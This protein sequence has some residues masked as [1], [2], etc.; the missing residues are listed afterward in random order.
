MATNVPRLSDVFAQRTRGAKMCRRPSAYSRA[1]LSR[2]Y[3]MGV[4]TFSKIFCQ[5]HFS[6]NQQSMNCTFDTDAEYY[7]Y[8]RYI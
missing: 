7:L 8:N 1:V 5:F 6:N 3:A 2:C 4:Q